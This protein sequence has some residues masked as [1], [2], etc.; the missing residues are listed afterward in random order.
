MQ[1]TRRR[2]DCRSG[3][4]APRLRKEP[5]IGRAGQ[6]LRLLTAHAGSFCGHARRADERRMIQRAAVGVRDYSTAAAGADTLCLRDEGLIRRF[7]AGNHKPCI[8]FQPVGR[9]HG[10]GANH[11]L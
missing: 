7:R 4:A 11:T 8:R 2:K 3:Y 5:C 9:R 6:H 1:I 10:A